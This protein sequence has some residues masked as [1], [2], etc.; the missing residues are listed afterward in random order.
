[1]EAYP[2]Q[3]RLYIVVG[4]MLGLMIGVFMHSF[5][6]QEGS[7]FQ[8]AWLFFFALLGALV[9][10]LLVVAQAPGEAEREAEQG[11]DAEEAPTTEESATTRYFKLQ[12]GVYDHDELRRLRVRSVTM[13]M[14]P[15]DSE[16]ALQVRNYDSYTRV[17][18]LPGVLEKLTVEEV[19]DRVHVEACG[20]APKVPRDLDLSLVSYH[21]EGPLGPDGRSP[22]G[23]TFYLVD[24]AAGLGCRATTTR[25]EIALHFHTAA[26]YSDIEAA[27]WV[28]VEDLLKWVEAALP[29]WADEE[30]R[31]RVNLPEDYLAYAMSPLRVADID[32]DGQV[33]LNEAHLTAPQPPVDELER[34]SLAEFVAF[35]RGEP[36]VTGDLYAALQEEGFADGLRTVNPSAMERAAIALERWHGFQLPDQLSAAIGET[37]DLLERNELVHILAR[38]P[39]GLA[40]VTL[41][42]LGV[43]SEEPE[44]TKLCHMLHQDRRHGV[45]D[46]S[47]HPLDPLSF[48]DGR[49]QM[50]RGEFRVV[51]LKPT[52]NPEAEFWPALQELGFHLQ[53]RRLLSGDANLLVGAQLQSADKLTELVLT[54]TPLPVPCHILHIVGNGAAELERLLNRTDIV[55]PQSKIVADIHSEHPHRVHRAALYVTALRIDEEDLVPHLIAGA[56]RG[57]RDPNLRRA[58]LGALAVQSSRVAQDHLE[59]IAVDPSHEDREYASRAVSEPIPSS[60]GPSV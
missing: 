16:V 10:K 6:L 20:R 3:T 59:A 28:D 22:H 11:S 52:Y 14:S 2:G 47:S 27:D 18:V 25:T 26:T 53:R 5:L 42:R 9:G 58:V 17:K 46:V 51:P 35:G 38:C 21:S 33:V 37:E 29:E 31:L 40:P 50:G 45:I 12:S 44:L 60:S 49:R 24:G 15:P 13:P 4:C 34:F 54:S 23:W 55:Y 32:V 19:F 48:L 43:E 57:K 41:H 39:G 1:M 7:N 56:D 8:V 36:P 30:V